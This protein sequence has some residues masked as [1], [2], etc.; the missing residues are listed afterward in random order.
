VASLLFIL[1]NDLLQA[2]WVA[3]DA[4]SES[5]Q[6]LLIVAVTLPICTLK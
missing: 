6:I 3:N 2:Y 4:P 5:Y 1:A